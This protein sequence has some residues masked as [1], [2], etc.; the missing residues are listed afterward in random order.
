MKLMQEVLDKV[1]WQEDNETDVLKRSRYLWLKNPKSL[2]ARQR[3]KLATL[4]CHNLKMARAYQIRLT[5]QELFTQP[6]RETGEAF[7]KRGYFW[8]THTRLQPVIEAA[9]AIKRHWE[10]V[11]NW[12]SSQLTLG[13][14]EG[15]NSFVQAAKA[16][17][18]GYRTARNL[19][20]MAYLLAGKLYFG[21]PT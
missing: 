3:G 14:L 19:I 4:K 20:T 21:L 1:R 8:A 12:F 15:I 9:K 18:R 2:T 16:K 13:F 7:L 5:L 11:L 10:G 6:K 17:A